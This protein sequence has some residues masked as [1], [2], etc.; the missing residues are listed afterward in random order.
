MIEA[1]AVYGKD[2]V[3]DG[4]VLPLPNRP[5][6][7]HVFDYGS[8]IWFDPRSLEELKTVKWSEIKKARTEAEVS[9]FT[10]D[11]VVFDSDLVSQQRISAAIQMASITA[12]AGEV[13]SIT[14]TLQDNSTRVLSAS[15]MS[16]VGISLG[17]H[18]AELHVKAQKLRASIDAATSPKE[19]ALIAW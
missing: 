3:L 14:W 1:V 19:L 12:A 4:V 17:N 5:S 8:K 9:G 6:P 18:V 15:D 11:G 13:F 2:Y 7:V 16:A 10:W